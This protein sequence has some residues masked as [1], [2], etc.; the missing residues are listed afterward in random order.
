MKN[1][2]I[3]MLKV[4]EILTFIVVVSV[5]LALCKIIDILNHLKER[6]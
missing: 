3:S 4:I 1:F 5:P 6:I 2:K